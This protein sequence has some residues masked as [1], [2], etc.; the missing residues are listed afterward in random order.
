MKSGEVCCHSSASCVTRALTTQSWRSIKANISLDVA[1]TAVR[2]WL[3]PAPPPVPAF[4]SPPLRS[5]YRS[6]VTRESSR[7][8]SPAPT[9]LR[10]TSHDAL[11]SLDHKSPTGYSSPVPSKPL[12]V[13]RPSAQ[14]DASSSSAVPFPR[15]RPASPPPKRPLTSLSPLQIS[16]ASSKSESTTRPRT[17]S[18]KRLSFPALASPTAPTSATNTDHV[19]PSITPASPSRHGISGGHFSISGVLGYSRANS[20]SGAVSNLTRLAE[21]HPASRSPILINRQKQN[22]PAS[23]VQDVARRSASPPPR[24]RTDTSTFNRD[25]NHDSRGDS[26]SDAELRRSN[27]DLKSRRK[28]EEWTSAAVSRK[29]WKMGEGPS[30]AE[31][32]GEF[33]DGVRKRQSAELLGSANASMGMTNGKPNIAVVFPPF[34]GDGRGGGTGAAAGN[35]KGNA[36]GQ[37]R[38][39]GGSL[40]RDSR[41]YGLGYGEVEEEVQWG[42]EV[43]GVRLGECSAMTGEGEWCADQLSSAFSACLG[44]PR[45]Q[46]PQ[47]LEHCRYI[48]RRTPFAVDRGESRPICRKVPLTFQASK[49]FSSQSHQCSSRRRTR[50]SGSGRSDDRA[51]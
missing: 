31:A 26:D 27:T 10:S 18:E 23:S 22:Q 32:L 25:F 50:S 4:L 14:V 13:S 12:L 35:G 49:H 9:P 11:A 43:E 44:P 38:K 2:R 20:M 24:V 48:L 7:P 30:A 40:G 29:S 15:A 42:I 36:Q 33:G 6:S 16:S 5:N 47:S 39:R 34:P 8:N 37:G 41:L 51:A 45:A 17:K 19:S 46:K 3:K 1:K 28:S 21:D